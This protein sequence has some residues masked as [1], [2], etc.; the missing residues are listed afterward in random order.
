M[1]HKHRKIL[2]SLYE[3]PLSGNIA[4]RDVASVFEELG[5][6][7]SHAG[8]GHILVKL[9]GHSAHFDG[10]AHSLAKDDAVKARKF[11]ET[12]G[13]DAMRDYPL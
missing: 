6:D 13:V 11:L 7:V 10:H 12:C 8:D 1:N 4:M 2:H 5:G 9:N 3:H